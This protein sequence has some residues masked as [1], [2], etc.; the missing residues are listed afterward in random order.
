[1][2]RIL[3]SKRLQTILSSL[4]PALVFAFLAGMLLQHVNAPLLERHSW[5]QADTAS[6][7]RGLAEGRF[8]VLH[9]RFLACYPDAYGLDGAVETEFNLYPL[10]VAGLY[11]LFGVHEALARLVSIAFSL[12]TAAWVYLLAKRY[13]GRRAALLATLFLGL[14]PLY[15]FYGRTVQ[16]EATALF[17]SVGAL[18]WF[19]QW[20]E[21]ERWGHWALATGMAAL[22]FLCK[23]PTLYIGLPLLGAA[24]LKW[25]WQ[26]FRQGWLWLFG[27]LTLAPAALY[28]LHAHQLY[29]QSGLTVYGI[30]GGWP[31]S[32]KFDT[33]GQLCSPDFYR[34]ML[35]RLRGIILGRYGFLCL[36]LG[37]ALRPRHR[38][39]GIL[40]LWLAAVGLFILGVAQG[41]R[42]H[43]YYQL[44]LVPVAALF[45]GKAL[46]ALSAPGALHL[47]VILLRQKL[48]AF[49]AGLLLLLN[50]RSA[51]GY[52]PKMYQQTEILLEVA[53]ATERLTPADAPVAIIYD[54]ARVPEVFYYAQRRGWALWLE[55]TPAG[56]Y[57]RLI[58]AERERTPKGWLIREKLES[59]PSRIEL[60]RAQGA[61]SLVVS[62]E[63]G[64]TS[65]FLRSPIG[66]ALGERYPLIGSGEHWLI[67]DL[68]HPKG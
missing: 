20:L 34:V 10:L 37:L 16:P 49:L 13:F 46:A 28:Y 61:A 50:L 29:L 3:Q 32:G 30:S 18:Y 64:T 42:Q 67:Y 12:G 65:E 44:P 8:D 54:W 14:S 33:W 5:R 66:R 23:I 36:L 19:T 6:F 40:Y 31:G 56:E 35:R 48:G 4:F 55:R 38:E 52:L 60:L 2:Q 43:E 41:N 25:R 1:M 47:D 21:S 39:E 59:D 68:R 15:V 63:K 22:A 7:A 9:P 26:L 24:W 11:R 17:F 45:V 57:G 51:W 27:L 53:A 58:I 62:L